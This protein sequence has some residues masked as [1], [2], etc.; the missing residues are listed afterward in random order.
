MIRIALLTILID[1]YLI[2]TFFLLSSILFLRYFFKNIL[3]VVIFI[4]YAIKWTDEIKL[5]IAKFKTYSC[6]SSKY[7]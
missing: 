2:P 6:D 3:F 1:N 4:F 7:S 5:D